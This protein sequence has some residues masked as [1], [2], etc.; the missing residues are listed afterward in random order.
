[1]ATATAMRARPRWTAER[2]FYTAIAIAMALAAYIGF[3]RSFFLHP[4]FPD[5]PAPAEPV[6][7]VHGIFFSAWCVLLVVQATL[8]GVRRVDLHR[9]LG[10]LGA[11]LAI[12]MLV[13]GLYGALV[14]ANRPTGFNLVPVPPLQFL[15]IP[16]FDLAFFGT[17]VGLALKRRA[18]AQAHKRLMVLATVALLAAA[19]A[20]WPYVWKIGN[21]FVYFGL[22][23]LFIVALAVWDF[24]TRGSLHPVTRWG[25]LTLILSLPLRLMLSTTSAWMA[26]AGWLTSLVR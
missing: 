16:I 7:I 1:M 5:W 2:K 22:A 17:F 8:I 11:G 10:L 3:A 9:T 25:G 26:F 15:V 18:D 20:R 23:D 13:L 19:F 21:P 4:F 14:A 24:R 6:F 12:G